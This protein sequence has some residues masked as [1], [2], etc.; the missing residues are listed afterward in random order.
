MRD[1]SRIDEA[2]NRANLFC[3][4]ID[5]GVYS[6]GPGGGGYMVIYLAK[7]HQVV[8]IDGREMCAAACTPNMMRLGSTS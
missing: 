5:L 1:R 7:T 3:H 2:I 8:T 4:G 6:T